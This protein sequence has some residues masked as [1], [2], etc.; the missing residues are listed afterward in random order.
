MTLEDYSFPNSGVAHAS[1]SF[2]WSTRVMAS[3]SGVALA[4]GVIGSSALIGAKG[5]AD[6][7]RLQPGHWLVLISTLGGIF[8]LIVRL[9]WQSWLGGA[10]VTSAAS[11]MPLQ[12]AVAL[13][14]L[15]LAA[16]YAYAAV[17]LGET[18][19]WRV[20]LGAQAVGSAVMLSVVLP[21]II[22]VAGTLTWHLIRVVYIV[23]LLVAPAAIL[24]T[25]MVVVVWDVR[26]WKLRD[27]VHWLGVG[28]VGVNW[29]CVLG[30]WVAATFLLRTV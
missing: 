30:W 1:S 18:K 15:F 26:R 23:S 12:I 28:L 6:L 19:R 10:T 7:R 22:A 14:N 21:I 25:L 27:W 11:V 13:C 8:L 17:R 20:L 4:F 3:V 29:L 2:Y 5:M 24:V 16:S 9:A